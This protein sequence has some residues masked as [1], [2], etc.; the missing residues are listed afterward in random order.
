M[1][2][3]QGHPPARLLNEV[4]FLVGSG[5]HFCPLVA[6]LQQRNCLK[7]M[8]SIQDAQAAWAAGSRRGEDDL[9]GR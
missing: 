6:K 9:G 5:I 3:Q 7:N 4:F 1:K 2:Y 8:N